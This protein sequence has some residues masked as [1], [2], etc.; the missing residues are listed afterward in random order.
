MN[1]LLFKTGY[2]MNIV[3]IMMVSQSIMIHVSVA[4][5]V[6]RITYEYVDFEYV[7]R[8]AMNI[9][10]EHTN[11]VK[12]LSKYIKTFTKSDLEFIRAM[13]VWFSS[14]TGMSYDFDCV[15]GNKKRPSQSTEHA[16]RT[17]VGVCVA[18][19]NIMVDAC[20]RVG[21]PAYYVTGKTA[22]LDEDIE[23]S[24]YHHA[25]VMVHVNGKYGLIDPTHGS[26]MGL[27]NS[28]ENNIT[29]I[30]RIN[31]AYF[32]YH[33]YEIG[34]RRK[35]DN[36]IYDLRTISNFDFGRKTLPNT[37]EEI[38][39]KHP[40]FRKYLDNFIGNS[41]PLH[42]MNEIHYNRRD[43]IFN[44]VEAR[45]NFTLGHTRVIPRMY[46]LAQKEYIEMSF[47]GYLIHISK[48]YKNRSKKVITIDPY[49]MHT[50]T[51]MK[52]QLLF[53]LD[54]SELNS[55]LAQK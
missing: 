39:A 43:T 33:P 49:S 46:F 42:T 10:I 30:K 50:Y 14:P 47:T 23:K 52:K 15:Y 28:D 5:S 38:I 22:E 31:N 4:Q 6:N 25:W 26:A 44:D 3:V 29:N 11:S 1:S 45:A 35:S 21:I 7:D 19:S 34:E 24:T 36:A 2:I 13:Y 55:S 27:R 54:N 48:E 20:N 41:L 12:D 16:L 40:V 51:F 9:P 32:F 53:F 17:K 18:Y 8:K 37:V